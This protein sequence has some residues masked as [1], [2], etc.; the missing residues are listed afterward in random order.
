MKNTVALAVVILL[1]LPVPVS[2]LVN[3]NTATIAELDTL[4]GVG[5]ATAEKI[6]NARPFSSIEEIEKVSGIDGPGTKIYE[7]LIGLITVTGA[8]TVVVDDDEEEEVTTSSAKQEEKRVVLPVTGLK[9]TAPLIA[10]VNQ[11]VNFS[12]APQDGV[13]NRLVRYL[14]SFG[15]GNTSDDAGP[16]HRYQHPG[17]YV[18]VVESYY[19]KETKV[20]RHEIEVLAPA[21]SLTRRAGGLAVTN[22]G[23]EEM[24]LYGLSVVSDDIFVF[25]KH[26]ILLPGE[27]VV[28]SAG[29]AKASIMDATG[30]TLTVEGMEKAKITPA[31]TS[32]VSV[33]E[34]NIETDV[35]STISPPI[36][37]E[38]PLVSVA[39][40]SENLAA[41]VAADREN[42]TWPYLGLALLVTLGVFSL[43]SLTPRSGT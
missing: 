32:S 23:E 29:V 38:N 20:A 21:L 19:N 34:P 15:D 22:D 18:V 25:P 27:S 16:S 30:R 12:V 33:A 6:V 1:L 36:G 17:K 7:G 41:P 10:H 4:P 8:T 31:L 35:V 24:D 28:I 39:H 5:P 13:R 42:E 14:W 26:T 37:P 9:L 11:V 43:F 40:A 3:I 2:A